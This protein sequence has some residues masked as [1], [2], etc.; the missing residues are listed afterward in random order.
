MNCYDRSVSQHGGDV[1]AS[2]AL[3]IGCAVQNISRRDQ[4]E[5]LIPPTRFI[6]ASTRI[7]GGLQWATYRSA[8]AHL[9]I[10]FLSTASS[11]V[12]RMTAVNKS[13]LLIDWQVS[14]FE[15]ALQKFAPFSPHFVMLDDCKHSL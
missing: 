14:K 7:L 11:D 2:R 13:R 10:V 1:L 3:L 9:L 15:H 12:P 8:C 4:R 6:N 5:A